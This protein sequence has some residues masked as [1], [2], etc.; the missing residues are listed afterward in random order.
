MNKTQYTFNQVTGYTT[1]GS[2]S[3]LLMLR[4][5]AVWHRAP[6]V[7]ASLAVASLGQWGIL[8]HG[9]VTVRSRSDVS[10]TCLVDY[11]SPVFVKLIYLYSESSA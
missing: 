1:L 4:T 7:T 6:L 3:T 10:K 5:I 8:L 9:I 2:A 11:A